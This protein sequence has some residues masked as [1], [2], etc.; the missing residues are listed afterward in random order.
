MKFELKLIQDD[1]E[2]Q[3]IW[4]QDYLNEMDWEDFE[5]SV[6][7]SQP[8]IGEMDGGITAGILVGALGGALAS[9]ADSLISAIWE[10]FK[11]KSITMEFEGEC[12][13]NGNKL[14]LTI[15]KI[16]DGGREKAI[17]DFQSSLKRFCETS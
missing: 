11:G 15:S 6:K 7:R 17:L 4:F 5:C 8:T 14:R 1:P 16:K 2:Q 12:P 3:A 13:N 10:F 9:Q